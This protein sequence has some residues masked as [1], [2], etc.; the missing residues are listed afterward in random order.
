MA[1]LFTISATGENN[2]FNLFYLLAIKYLVLP[3]INEYMNT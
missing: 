2:L 1:D 3:E